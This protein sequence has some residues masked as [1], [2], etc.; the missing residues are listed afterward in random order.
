VVVGLHVC[1]L[2]VA[3]EGLLE[4]LLAIN[5]VSRQVVQPDPSGVSQVNGKELD[6]EEVVIHPAHLA[7]EA[8]VF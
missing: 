8:I 2:K 3:D 7:H 4:I 6:D 1:A 5:H